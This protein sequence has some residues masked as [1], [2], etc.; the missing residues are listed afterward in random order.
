MTPYEFKAWFDGFTASDDGPPSLPKRRVINERVAE[1]DGF[2]LDGRMFLETFYTAAI[3]APMQ[4]TRA[5]ILRGVTFDSE[6]LMYSLGQ[7]ESNV[8]FPSES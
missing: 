7:A 6:T 8:L 1:V 5:D 4:Q 3:S 2:A